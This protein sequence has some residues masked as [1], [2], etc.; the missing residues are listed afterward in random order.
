MGDVCGKG[1]AAAT[2]TSMVK[3]ALRGL[4]GA[5]LEPAAALTEL[6]RQL[7]GAGDP[8]DIVTVWL[9]VLDL[10]AGT[11]LYAN[12]GHPP[13]LLLRHETRRVERL[14]ASGPLLGGIPETTYEQRSIALCE[15]DLLVLYT[16]GVTESRCGSHFFGEGR[17]RRALRSCDNAK[18]CIDHLLEAIDRFSAGPLRDD[19]AALAVRRVHVG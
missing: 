19:A 18:D 12:G 17:V 8:S 3:Y 7:A 6:N 10:D 4:I 1:V 2:K 5:G 16:D 11:L 9:G 13:G 14:V 15:D